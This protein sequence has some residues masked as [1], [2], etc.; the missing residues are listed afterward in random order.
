MGTT[1]NDWKSIATAVGRPSVI[2]E[3]AR[4]LR[5]GEMFL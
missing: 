3:T 4:A 5:D 2:K 1:V